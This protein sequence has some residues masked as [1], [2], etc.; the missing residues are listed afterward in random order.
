MTMTDNSIGWNRKR[1]FFPCRTLAGILDDSGT[2]VPASLG[3]G[4]MVFAE[5]AATLELAGMQIGADGDEAYHFW[6]IPWDFDITQPI[7]GRVWFVSTSTDADTPVFSIAYKG[8]GKQ[9]AV[10]DAKSSPDGTL[11]FPA[12]TISTT[13]NSLEITA[14]VESTS[15]NVL[16]ATDFALL[17]ALTVTTMS[18]SANELLILGFEI[19]YTIAAAPGPDRKITERAVL[20]P[21]GPNG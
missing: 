5:I 15:Q 12:H 18:A 16:T 3:A 8:I 9:A 2:G 17:L 1:K 4:G 21:S 14:W 20:A 19:D 6:P 13:D 7:R 11:T 10:T